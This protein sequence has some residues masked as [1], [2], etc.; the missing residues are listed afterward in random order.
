[1]GAILALISAIAW[2]VADYIGGIASRKAGATPVLVA[3]YPAGA[4]ILSVFVFLFS[5]LA[6]MLLRERLSRV[7]L[8]GVVLALAAAALLALA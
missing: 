1:M 5:M 8:V 3:A 7:Q 4:V 6:R 2:G